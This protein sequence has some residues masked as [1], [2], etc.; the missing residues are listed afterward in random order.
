[1]GTDPSVLRSLLLL[2]AELE[3]VKDVLYRANLIDPARLEGAIEEIAQ[4]ARDSPPCH[5]PMLK[6]TLLE[7]LHTQRRE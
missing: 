5:S 2:A 3:S 1:M 6:T 4:A 7:L